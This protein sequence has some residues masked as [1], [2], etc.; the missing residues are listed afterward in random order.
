VAPPVQRAASVEVVG[1]PPGSM[2]ETAAAAPPVLAEGDDPAHPV[3]ARRT[4]GE[5][6]RLGLGAPLTGRPP[7]AAWETGRPDLPVARLARPTDAPGSTSAHPPIA[8][9][10]PAAAAAS[11]PLPR[12]VVARR[13]TTAPVAL[14]SQVSP[15]AS[16]AADPGSAGAPV[17][18]SADGAGESAVGGTPSSTR[19]L[20]GDTPIGV[21]RLARED[22]VMD[23]DAEGAAEGAA[24]LGVTAL[25]LA[26]ASGAL[27]AA[28]STAAMDPAAGPEPGATS[29]AT[30]SSPLAGESLRAGDPAGSAD[31]AAVQR[32]HSMPA[33][34]ERSRAAGALL[35]TRTTRALA[36][37]VASRAMRAGLPAAMATLGYGPTAEPAP[38]V[39]RLAIPWLGTA[40]GGS[41]VS[42]AAQRDERPFVSRSPLAAGRS[43]SPATISALPLARS[44]VG[45]V[46]PDAVETGRPGGVVGWAA[47]EGFTSAGEGFTSAA[48]SHGPFVQR[49]VT[50]DEVT[51]TPDADAAG[52]AGS[53]A[54]AGSAGQP[55][56]TGAGGAGTDYEE[57]AEHVYDK[58]RA[59]LTTELL[60]D[61]ERAGMLVDG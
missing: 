41:A 4:L 8:P 32:S 42:P 24:E 35:T 15:Q 14:V 51:A 46:E 22:A 34:G 37:L 59:R 47:G 21:S 57:L 52:P 18:A 2:P 10:V 40:G 3:V 39:A 11:A 50:I 7:S 5:S 54:T 45:T 49:A 36:P 23:V 48:L 25:R 19:P 29:G 44:A 26:G 27:P 9:P 33:G 20:V 6:R 58:I 28:T 53:G 1:P 61:R 56:A 31:L 12:L 30:S 13:S 38:V 55:G 16:G 17:D 60:L 43:P